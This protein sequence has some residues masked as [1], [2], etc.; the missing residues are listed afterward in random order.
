MDVIAVLD[1]GGQYCHLIGRRV[2]DLGYIAE[3][4]PAE[5]TVDVLNGIDGLKGVIL[6]GGAMSV[7]GEDSPK[8]DAG[9]LDMGLPVLGICYGHQLIAHTVGGYVEQAE[10]GEFGITQMEVTDWGGYL[11]DFAK[12]QEV[13]MNHCDIVKSLPEGFVVSAKTSHSEVALFENRERKLYGIQFH[14]EV[15]HTKAGVELI[16]RFVEEICGTSVKV[17]MRDVVEHMIEEARRGIGDRRAVLGLSGG[18]DSSVAAVIVGRAVG[19]QL[20]CVYVDTGLMRE[21]ET[22][23]IEEVFGG[24]GIDVRVV[25]AEDRFF[26]ALAGI[27]DPEDKRKT[28]GRVFIEV[29]DEVAKEIGAEVLVQGTIYSDRIESGVSQ[30]S[31]TIKSHHNVG[32]L[33][34]EMNL[35]VYEPLAELY[36]DEVRRIAELV[37]LPE[38]LVKRQSF[39]G[40][41]L[42]IR[43]LGEVTKEKV[44]IVRKASAIVE[45]EMVG[46]MEFVGDNKAFAVLLPVKVVGVQGDA[47][48]YRYPVVVRILESTD[49][50]SANFA[51]L[52][53]SVLGKISTRITNEIKDVNRVVYDITNKPPGTMEWE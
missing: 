36:K 48:T 8:M 24:L 7:Y 41:G 1:F 47:R 32:G 34:K 50:M 18:V 38:S 52:D 27:T 21:G 11:H 37:G 10:S 22:E 29:F 15:T 19:E 45:Q 30:H 16:R 42:G 9:I 46:H 43:V 35:G 40:P 44:A 2:R 31:S 6:S 12:D 23:S 17:E 51:H 14:P 49:V 33:P 25:R 3:V 13:W 26:E 28:I 4:L 53:W 39:P 5:T 20:T